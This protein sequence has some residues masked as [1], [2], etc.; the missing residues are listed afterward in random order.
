MPLLILMGNKI[1]LSYLQAVKP[2]LHEKF[3]ED[4]KLYSF[5]VSAKTGDQ[6]SSCFFKIAAD[7]AGIE[8]SKPTIEITQK[9]VVAEIV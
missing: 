2:E 4:N 1:D 7:L 8:V 3:S 9:Q 5:Y 6:I